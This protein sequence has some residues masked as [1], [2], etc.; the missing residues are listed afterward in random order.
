MAGVTYAVVAQLRGRLD[1]QGKDLEG[2]VVNERLTRQRVQRVEEWLE[3]FTGL[4][5]WGRL[6][7][8][9]LGRA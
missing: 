6:K 5:L 8:L 3:A 2:A 7:W 1:A 4:S 9:L